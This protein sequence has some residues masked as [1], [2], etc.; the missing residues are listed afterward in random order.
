MPGVDDGVG[1]TGVAIPLFATVVAIFKELVKRAKPLSI[2]YSA[3]GAS[4][5]RLYTRFPRMIQ[6]IVPGYNVGEVKP[7]SYEVRHS[8]YA[9]MAKMG[10]VPE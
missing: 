3:K 10:I 4:R 8:R 6:R 9:D 7:G 1:K 5:A 2:V